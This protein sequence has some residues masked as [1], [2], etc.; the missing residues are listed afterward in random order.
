MHFRR[1]LGSVIFCG[2]ILTSAGSAAAEV[3]NKPSSSAAAV[4]AF[5]QYDIPDHRRE[6]FDYKKPTPLMRRL[7]S[8]SLV[9]DWF[10]AMR[11]R[12]PCPTSEHA[13][14]RP[15]AS[16]RWP[17]SRRSGFRKILHR[18]WLG[19]AADPA[20]HERQPRVRVVVLER[21]GE[22]FWDFRIGSTRPRWM[23]V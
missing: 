3:T 1:H 17:R 16:A 8:K 15:A 11:Q 7:L 18:K 13:C 19:H 14:A 12:G 5:L 9:A 6:V 21:A 23:A 4:Q 20:W 10:T 22:L 2:F